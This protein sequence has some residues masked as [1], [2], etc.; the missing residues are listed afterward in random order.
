M[1]LKKIYLPGRF[2]YIA[3]FLTLNCNFNCDY[4]IN[5]LE[6]RDNKW[7]QISGQ[8]WTHALNR[9]VSRRDLPIT[10]Q[11]GEPS[12]HPDFFSIINNIETQLNIDILTNLS[13]D[14]EKFAKEVNPSR[15]KREAPYSSIRASYHS[16]QMSADIFIKK[17]LYL[18][19]AGFSVG[20]YGVLHPLTKDH[21]LETKEKCEQFGIDFR[22][23]DFLGQ[24]EGELKGLYKFEGSVGSTTRLKCKCRTTELIIGP[25][26]K[27]YRCHHDLYK[28][29]PHIGN[30]LEPEFDIEDIFRDCDQ[31]GDCNPCDLK[32][33]TNRFQKFG[34]C[35]VDI[36]DI[37]KAN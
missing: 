18:Q 30:L 28:G 24:H 6:N 2:N 36:K 37:V 9:L 11:G 4:C 21:V 7:P 34:H 5:W 22:V 31:Y 25:D 20:G 19:K 1:S 35:S 32:I 27:V 17:I 10:L 3:C 8:D 23:K 29:F 12:L 26:C 33:K 16:T 14:V 13:F 15:L